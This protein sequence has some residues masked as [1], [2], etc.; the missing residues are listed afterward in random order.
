MK[1]ARGGLLKTERVKMTDSEIITNTLIRKRLLK[2]PIAPNYE[3]AV[4]V[5]PELKST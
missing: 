2:G 4:S 1:G 5:W 3:K